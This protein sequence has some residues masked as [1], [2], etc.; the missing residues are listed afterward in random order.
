MRLFQWP[1]YWLIYIVVINTW[2]QVAH[3][4]NNPKMD[5]RVAMVVSHVPVI[6]ALLY[7]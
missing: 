7:V 2:R 6:H 1:L 3:L 5:N 4:S